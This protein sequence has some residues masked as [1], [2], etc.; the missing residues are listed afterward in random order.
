MP[1]NDRKREHILSLTTYLAA[2]R[3]RVREGNIIFTIP[4]VI[5]LEYFLRFQQQNKK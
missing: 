2:V 5:K 4:N 3:L 1:L